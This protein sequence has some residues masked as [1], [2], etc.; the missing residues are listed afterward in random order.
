MRT[1]NRLGLVAFAVAI[2]P[3]GLRSVEGQREGW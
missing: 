1:L 3:T 2:L